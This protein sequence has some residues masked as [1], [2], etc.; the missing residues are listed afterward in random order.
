MHMP[1]HKPKLL[2]FDVNE[3][4]L[5]LSPMRTRMQEIFQHEFAFEKWFSLMLHYSLVDNVTNQYH[6]FGEI[7]KA[8]FQ[9]TGQILERKVSDKDVQ[10]TL[11]MIRQ[12]PPHPDIPEGLDMLKKAGYKMIALTNSTGEVVKEQMKNAGLTEN[13]EALLSIDEF[14][15]Y[16]PSLEV[17][18]TV[19]HK[20][21][22]QPHEAMMIAAHGWD[23]TGALQAG[24]Q[25]AFIARKGKALYP[26]AP[27]PQL[28]GN[29][30][31]SIAENL[32]E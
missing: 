7:G 6:N 14:R 20:F 11:Q 21:G 18:K 31:V 29:T 28:T 26:L 8:A 15:K 1:S 17:Y 16:K 2:I 30:L 9:M 10:E 27:E 19:V 4:L 25:A 23:V 24:L 22:I 12:L 3:T 13:F 5:D 32:I